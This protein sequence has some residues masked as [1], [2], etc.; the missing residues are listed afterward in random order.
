[1]RL[2]KNDFPLFLSVFDY[3]W[4]KRALREAEAYLKESKKASSPLKLVYARMSILSSRMMITMLFPPISRYE[5]INVNEEASNPIEYRLRN[6]YDKALEKVDK[7]QLSE[8][9]AVEISDF[10]YTLSSTIF[11]Q[12][13]SKN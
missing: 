12:I 9:E 13:L 1:M 5:N 2:E 4:L 6:L 7:I 11:E 10:L 8:D 3:G